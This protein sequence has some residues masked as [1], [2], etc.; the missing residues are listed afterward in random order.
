[1]KH[2]MFLMLCDGLLDYASIGDNPQNIIE[3]E[4]CTPL[5]SIHVARH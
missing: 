3:F 2:G 1:M 5:S 4:F